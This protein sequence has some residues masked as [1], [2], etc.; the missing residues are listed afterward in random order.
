MMLLKSDGLHLLWLMGVC[1]LYCSCSNAG[2]EREV[3]TEET[4]TE[5]GKL[6]TSNSVASPWM[7][8]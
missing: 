1:L 2:Q 5:L 3:P 8:S 7:L 4:L 6:P